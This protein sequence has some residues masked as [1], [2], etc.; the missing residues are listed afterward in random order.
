VEIARGR[1]SPTFTRSAGAVSVLETIPAIPPEANSTALD[2]LLS[3]CAEGISNTVSVTERFGSFD[4]NM[5]GRERLVGCWKQT[6]CQVAR[7]AERAAGGPQ[8]H[9]IGQTRRLG[10][11]G[12]EHN[13]TKG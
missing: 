8:F 12:R 5:K 11:F 6:T 4:L 2:V 7:V 10:M 1:L 3:W 9:R 13:T